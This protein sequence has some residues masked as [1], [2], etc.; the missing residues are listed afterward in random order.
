MA[1]TYVALDLETTGLDPERDAIIE[2]GAVRF[3]GERVFETFSTLVNPGRP[4]PFRIQQLTGITDRDVAGAP[5]LRAV[6]GALARF[7][8]PHTV[9]GHNVAFD[10]S[11]L[12]R[13]G[14]LRGQ[15]SLDTFELAGILMPHAV[16]YSLGRLADELGIVFPERHRALADAQATHALFLALCERAR[17]LPDDVLDEILR[18]SEGVEWPAREVFLEA[19]KEQARHAFTGG[20][21]QQLRDKGLLDTEGS[22][23]LLLSGEEDW[24]ELPPLEPGP[25]PALKPLDEEEVAGLLEEGGLVAR[26][27]PNYEY[28]AEQVQ[29]LRRVVQAL[30]TGEHLLVEAGTGTGKS[31]AYLLPAAYFA[32]RNKERIVISTNTINLQDQLFQKDIPDLQ[33]LLPFPF[34]A[35]L[36]K[37]RS[38]YLCLRKLA[39]FRSRRS[40]TPDEVRLLAKV[41]VWL[42]STLTGDRA[43]LFLPSPAESALWER[44]A[45]D[46][47]TCAAERCP[48]ARQGR[49]FF[50][51][52][53]RR[54]ER[55]HL[56]VVNHALLLSDVAMENRVLPE[57]RHLIVDEAHHLEDSAT[58][59]LGFDL[60]SRALRRWL[61]S[62]LGL[63]EEARATLLS[64]VWA[65]CKG[66]LK[67]DQ[68]AQM[69]QALDDLRHQ[70]RT[71]LTALEEFLQ[72]VEEFARSQVGE[73]SNNQYD[74]RI[75]LHG[76]ARAQPAW[77]RVEVLWDNAA[78]ILHRLNTGLERLGTTL[79][80][81]DGQG[82]DQMA[83]V[84]QDLAMLRRTLQTW[85]E[86]MSAV[87]SNPPPNM[88]SWVQ[89]RARDG[90][91]SLHAVPLHVGPLVEQHFFRTKRSVILTS[92]TLRTGESFDFL[93]ERLHAW[94]ADELAVGSPFD[95][96]RST[97]LFIPND[98]PEPNTPGYQKAVDQA[99]LAAVRAARGR[100]LV[101]FTSY[102]QLQAT[103]RAVEKP[104]AEEGIHI[105]VQG[106]GASRS[107][108]LET[109]RT[110]ESVALFGTRSFWEGV[111]VVGEALSC[112]I[113][114]RLPFAVPTE[115][116]F[117]ARAEGYDEPF[118]QYMV[119][120][121]ILRLRQG[122]GRL[123]RSRMDRGV[124]VILDRRVLTKTYGQEFL[125]SL[126]DCT[127]LQRPASLLPEA[128]R[129]W[130]ERPA[131]G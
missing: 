69:R 1:Q 96:R 91:V 61:D 73:G 110:G 72:A 47:D 75:R 9:V 62:A 115:P 113:I 46:P 80:L 82:S 38:H 52:A 59:Q 10:L 126:P 20:I 36:L 35:A 7:V 60:D 25:E 129:R 55:A 48:Y 56:I 100:T 24:D 84:L 29:M 17:Q 71:F 114:T 68:E 67:G 44:I 101:L 54:A 85:G 83:G 125:A 8:G 94:E 53:R 2:I 122:F 127:V 66:K 105:L 104:L 131:E 28:R 92:A 77:S 106:E 128:I 63:E 12:Q 13:Q 6:A 40:F 124:V 111:D 108:L 58:N 130:L 118:T 26:S 76:A 120:E 27:F 16:R 39:G 107:Q 109:F 65:V 123:I 45:S 14:I 81:L 41:L 74:Q 64:D 23:A 34:R 43:E 98:I 117:Q 88:V 37:G 22:A 112:L 33:R 86:Q 116:V 4:I 79:S 99:V 87:V 90:A 78:A 70:G 93:R 51:R 42:P 31:L 103:A 49:C 18:A 119:P 11:F 121:A 32:V 50:R 15:P 30:N 97:L 19:R 57:Y 95:Y 89:V 102:S 5:P 3:R 21:G